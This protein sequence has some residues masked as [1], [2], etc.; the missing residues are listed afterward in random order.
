[1][2]ADNI[3][4]VASLILAL[5]RQIQDI[6]RAITLIPTEEVKAELYAYMNELDPTSREG[7]AWSLIKPLANEWVEHNY[8]TH[9][10][11]NGHSHPSA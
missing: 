6:A 1:M 8:V 4:R 5:W 10:I 11:Y 3:A 7:I 9:N 2:P